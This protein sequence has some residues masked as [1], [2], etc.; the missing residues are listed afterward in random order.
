MTFL[1][2]LYNSVLTYAQ[3]NDNPQAP[4]SEKLCKLYKL[5]RRRGNNSLLMNC[6]SSPPIIVALKRGQ[7]DC[8]AFHRSAVHNK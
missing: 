1:I 5:N 3:I 4:T 2:T 8:A 7:S 6:K